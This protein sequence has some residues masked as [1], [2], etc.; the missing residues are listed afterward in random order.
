MLEAL[1]DGHVL[2]IHNQAVENWTTK[3]YAQPSVPGDPKDRTH[4]IINGA[5]NALSYEVA[6]P[7]EEATW[8]GQ[9]YITSEPQPDPVNALA[10]L[11]RI[12]AIRI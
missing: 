8:I 10:G 4:N 6:L 2:A 3:Q 1:V 5:Q 12:L 9:I 7:W 11:E